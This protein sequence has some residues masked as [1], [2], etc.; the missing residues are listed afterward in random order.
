MY[1][2]NMA[3]IASARS[4]LEIGDLGYQ[5]CAAAHGFEVSDVLRES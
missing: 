2:P 4:R 5:D 1:W 3:S